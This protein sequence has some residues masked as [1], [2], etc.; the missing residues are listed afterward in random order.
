[1]R[2]LFAAFLLLPLVQVR[3]IFA[4]AVPLIQSASSDLVVVGK[5]TQITLTGENL[6][7]G[8]RI[9]VIGEPG[10]TASVI[11]PP[12]TKPAT[13]QPAKNP[14]ELKINVTV[15][16]DAAR[17]AREIR[18]VTPKGVSKPHVISVED[19]APVV[20]KEPNH[21]PSEAQ[22]VDLPAIIV[23]AIRQP[24][25][26]DYFRFNARKSQRLIFEVIASR[27]GSRLD[28]S[29]YLYDVYGKEVAHDEDTNGLDSLID[30]T[31]PEDGQYVL[32]I[33]DLRFQGGGDFGYRIKAGEIPYVDAIFPLGGKRGQNVS[34][35]LI[36]RNLD[37]QHVDM[38]L[39]ASSPMGRRDVSAT[40]PRGV[41]NRRSFDVGD[42]P[43]MTEAEPNDAP[44]N[45]NPATMPVV[46]N[47][48]IGQA[49]DADCFRYKS[50]TTQSVV[51]EVFAQR[52]GSALD[53]L[54][55]LMDGEGRVLARNDDAAGSDSRIE[56]KAEA[57]KEYLVSITDVLGRGGSNYPYRLQVAPLQV[58]LPDFDVVFLPESPRV[59]RGSNMKLWCQVKR[60]GGFDGDVVVALMNVPVGVSCEPLLLRGKE[61]S[62]GL[63]VISAAADAPVGFY[64][65]HLTATGS[66]GDRIITHM[67]APRGVSRSSPEVYLSV[68][69]K[70]PF[71]ISRLG[72]PISGDAARVETETAALRKKLE[73]QTPE[74]D[75][76][77]AKWEAETLAKSQWEPL[78]I[79]TL[80]TRYG[81]KI[82]QRPDGT[83]LADGPAPEN[84][85]YNITYTTK[86]V[87]ITAFKLEAI[88]EDNK[89]PGRAPDG[90]FV[91]S[92]IELQATH[93]TPG[94]IG[95]AVDLE[96]PQADFTQGGFSV[97]QTLDT[98]D[99]NHQ[100]GWAIFPQTAQSHWALWRVHTPVG[101]E[102][103][104]TLGF[105]LKHHYNGGAPYLLRK[106]RLMAS[107]KANA[108]GDFS[109]PGN[110]LMALNAPAEKRSD[111]QKVELSAYY[112][113]IAPEL[114][115]TRERLTYLQ[116]AAAPFPPV[117]VGNTTTKL[118]VTVDRNGFDGDVKLTVEGYAAG[119][120]PQ[121]NEPFG[122]DKNLDIKP[123]TL[124]A[125][126]TQGVI[127]IKTSAKTEKGRR[128]IVVK[129][130]GT[131]NGEAYAEY[132]Q[133]IPMTVKE[134][135]PVP[136]AP[137]KKEPAKEPVKKEAEK[138]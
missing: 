132:S 102:G 34:L 29:L 98:R 36:G 117:A 89:G 130:E 92:A 84:E 4:Q 62:S 21:S 60:K 134:A 58:Q 123:I 73:S 120:D 109:L 87:G 63:M 137:P 54:L 106:F 37:K 108:A 80:V 86:L 1:M 95:M 100:G 121:T 26:V 81:S 59:A 20:E 110:V 2:I 12:A 99:P 61:Q 3:F 91:L 67:L 74:L 51:C 30:Y 112:R 129:A 105:T 22:S 38:M 5:S 43:E 93:Q 57:G 40:T 69:E 70:P 118:L 49:G 76:A 71:A 97:E 133:L 77:Q 44:A 72:D 48:R 75:A 55:T 31:V 33:Q 124:K 56:F 131:V 65:L 27:I 136:P 35:E 47:G 68:L 24:L 111:A 103:G 46:I 107:T 50:P 88:A 85:V 13:T 16:A 104:T 23:G 115:E 116:A 113:S 32:K 8:T 53:S 94:A 127:E 28:S 11:V 82:S 96:K 42:L 41:S 135:P 7:D 126:E 6:G 52:Y 122:I 138:K 9:M 79:V 83:I 90:N 17:G 18:V 66:V 10:V 119:L 101:K 19:Y 114:K 15:S 45:A 25:E 78:E 128:T 64:P 39:D 125:K 14:K